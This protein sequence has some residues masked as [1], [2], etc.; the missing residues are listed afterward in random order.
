[1]TEKELIAKLQELKQVK[2]RTEWV[3]LSKKNILDSAQVTPL[4]P[5]RSIFSS[6]ISGS[7][8]Q[9]LA[10]SFAILLMTIVSVGV[11][12]IS[13]EPDI[14][15]QDTTASILHSQDKKTVA[16]VF[17]NDV[18]VKMNL[19]KEKSKVL[20][21]DDKSQL[22]EAELKELQTMVSNITEDIQKDPKLAKVAVGQ[23]N[24]SITY[25]NVIDSEDLQ[26]TSGAFIKTIIEGM[27][28]YYKTVT[29][30]P[31]KQRQLE[32]IEE[33][34]L[35]EKSGANETLEGILMLNATSES[36]DAKSE[37]TVDSQIQPTGQDSQETTGASD[38]K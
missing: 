21:E 20:A 36:S 6:L 17:G 31:E 4:N 33:A 28:D 2:P 24:D 26:K 25:L 16:L 23:I 18:A 35:S 34:Y 38:E 15:N 11:I 29:L 32:A 8:R 14:N 27:F 12:G 5:V 3:V 1:M 37:T 13:G 19:I 10:Y 7:Y 9:E 22:K 30:T